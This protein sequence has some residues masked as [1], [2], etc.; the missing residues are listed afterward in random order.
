MLAWNRDKTGGIDAAN[1]RKH[2]LEAGFSG[3]F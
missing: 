2:A 1:A 3:D